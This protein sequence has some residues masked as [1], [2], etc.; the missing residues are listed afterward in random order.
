MES[1][2]TRQQV[3]V[4]INVKWDEKDVQALGLPKSVTSVVFQTTPSG[5][6]VMTFGYI[7]PPLIW[8][9]TEDQVKQAQSLKHKGVQ[10]TPVVRLGCT[11][12]TARE[13]H[14]ALGQQIGE[15]QQ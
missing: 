11:L 4:A 2:Q 6:V 8:G 15:E 7:N 13:I 10:V 12:Q 3:N 5:E 1:Q 9:S 14:Q